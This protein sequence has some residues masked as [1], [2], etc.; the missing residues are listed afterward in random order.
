MKHGTHLC[1][2]FWIHF[3][4][5]SPFFPCFVILNSSTI[6]DWIKALTTAT[7]TVELEMFA[8]MFFMYQA[9]CTVQPSTYT[10]KWFCL[11]QHFLYLP[12]SVLAMLF[13]VSFLFLCLVCIH[14]QLFPRYLYKVFELY[15]FIVFCWVSTF[16]K[17]IIYVLDVF[18]LIC[19]MFCLWTMV[20]YMWI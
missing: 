8:T 10:S 5:Y 4:L 2:Y 11:C 18:K 20:N 7:T 9:F 19:A 13:L 14:L 1:C 12:F 17:Y 15:C 3:C 16:A 6:L